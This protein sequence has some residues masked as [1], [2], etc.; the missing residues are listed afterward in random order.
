MNRHGKEKWEEDCKRCE[1]DVKRVMKIIRGG[2]ELTQVK[3]RSLLQK[4]EL[5]YY[6]ALNNYYNRL[7]HGIEI[8]LNTNIGK[9]IRLVHLNG[10]VV[11]QNAIIGEYVTIFQQVTIGAVEGKVGAPRIGNNVYIGAGAKILGNVEIG[12]NVKVGAN[13][14]VTKNVPNDVTVVGINQVLRK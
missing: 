13:A 14:V 7:L 9:G 1:G 2:Y 5:L 3:Q 10:I 4:I 12:D 6:K 11:N 8:P